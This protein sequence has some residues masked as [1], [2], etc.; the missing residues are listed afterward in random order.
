MFGVDYSL[1][2]SVITEYGGEPLDSFDDSSWSTAAQLECLKTH[3]GEDGVKLYNHAKSHYKYA[4]EHP[5]Q[6]AQPSATTSGL[7][8]KPGPPGSK[9]ALKTEFIHKHRYLSVPMSAMCMCY[10]IILTWPC[11]G[12]CQARQFHQCLQ[13]QARRELWVVS[14]SDVGSKERPRGDCSPT[15][16]RCAARH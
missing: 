11:V 6:P 2:G 4:T 3:W 5:D 14:S 8:G 10:S 13:A 12:M 7:N 9:Y 16:P 15:D 1:T